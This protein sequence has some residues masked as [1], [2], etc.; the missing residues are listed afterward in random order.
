LDYLTELFVIPDMKI[1]LKKL[2]ERELDTMKGRTADI[3]SAKFKTDQQ[4]QSLRLRK[5]T[6]LYLLSRSHI[7]TIKSYKRK[8][9]VENGVTV[10]NQTE[11]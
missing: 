4:R 2:N 5:I 9:T 7:I 10:R 1:N 11:K 3:H 6:I 8:T